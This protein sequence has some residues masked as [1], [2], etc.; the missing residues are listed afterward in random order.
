ME[1]TFKFGCQTINKHREEDA[2]HATAAFGRA[3]RHRKSE[4]CH[5]WC[6]L[7]FF[8]VSEKL[9]LRLS[10]QVC[11]NTA[12]ELLFKIQGCGYPF[13]IGH[14]ELVIIGYLN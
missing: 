11:I 4:P 3:A 14:E 5:Q 12:Y 13:S 2:Q 1:C 6:G 9:Y 10:Y 8:T 7:F